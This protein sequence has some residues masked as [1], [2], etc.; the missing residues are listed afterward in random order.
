MISIRIKKITNRNV[1]D[2]TKT[3]NRSIVTVLE[4][5]KSTIIGL[6]IENFL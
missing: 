6:N 2:Q 4:V 5:V 3:L 1:Q